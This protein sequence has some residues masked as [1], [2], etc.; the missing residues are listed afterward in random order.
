MTDA[1]RIEA[2]ELSAEELLRRLQEGTRIVI[3]RE[4]LGSAHE[5][6]LRYDGDV[7]Y[8]DTP[9]TLHRHQTQDGMRTCLESQG[10]CK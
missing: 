9:T 6:T 5:I 8:C 3:K 2:G 7:Y 10:Y 4:F 1:L